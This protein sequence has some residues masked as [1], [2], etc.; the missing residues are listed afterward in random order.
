MHDVFCVCSGRY[1]KELCRGLSAEFCCSM[2]GGGSARVRA[3]KGVKGVM[4]RRRAGPVVCDMFC[5]CS[6]R[7]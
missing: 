5:V 6:G 3:A 2:W 1:L 7:N 4:Q